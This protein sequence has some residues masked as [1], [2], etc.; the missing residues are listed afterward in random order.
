MPPLNLWPGEPPAP[1]APTPGG[2]L[3]NGGTRRTNARPA[4]ALCGPHGGAPA[5]AAEAP[6]LSETAAKTP[7]S[8]LRVAALSERPTARKAVFKVTGAPPAK[9]RGAWPASNL[10]AHCGWGVG[11]ALVAARDWKS[12]STAY[13]QNPTHGFVKLLSSYITT[14]LRDMLKL[15]VFVGVFNHALIREPC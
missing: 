7:P 12:C 2:A 14:M 15:K 11:G 3:N 8:P 6:E 10:G 1:P 9:R 13:V 5:S 4:D